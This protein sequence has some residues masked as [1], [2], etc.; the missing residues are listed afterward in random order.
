MLT[1]ATQWQ[2]RKSNRIERTFTEGLGLVLSRLEWRDRDCYT[3]P[4]AGRT[5]DGNGSHR[6]VNAE[7]IHKNWRENS[8]T[9]ANRTN[10]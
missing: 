3:Y 4:Y 10:N 1:N 8:C 2:T 5:V 7:P 9:T 6:V